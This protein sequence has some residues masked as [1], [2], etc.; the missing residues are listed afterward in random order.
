MPER[1][2][3]GSDHAGYQLKESVKTRLRQLGFEVDDVGTDSEE[4]TDY[5]DYAKRVASVVSSGDAGRGVLMC[6]TGLGMAYAANRYE[7]VRAAVAW[8]PEVA[9]L[10]GTTR[11]L[12]LEDGLRRF[13]NREML[14]IVWRDLCGLAPL[15]E[16][17]ASLTSLA[18]ICLQAAI[19][20]HH[21][22]LVENHGTPRGPDGSP[23]GIF[24]IGLGKFGGGELNL[25]SD[26]DVI[27]CYPQTGLFGYD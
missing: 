27:F 2:P 18:E 11:E 13:R 12:G 4:S 1:I 15:S 8:S 7:M 3:I 10:S 22:R 9:R 5:P 6:G 19:E 24:V 25:S 17:F 14:R 23:Q 16:T 26:I 20:E 21:R